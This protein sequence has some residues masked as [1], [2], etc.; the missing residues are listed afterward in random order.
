MKKIS[1]IILVFFVIAISACT[2][3]LELTPEVSATH[4]NFWKTE[5]DAIG[6]VH[7]LMASVKKACGPGQQCYNSLRGFICD[8]EDSVSYSFLQVRWTD[9]VVSSQHAAGQMPGWGSLYGNIFKCHDIIENINRVEW[10]NPEFR[11]FW[12]GQ[13]HF[14]KAYNYWMIVRNFGDAPMVSFKEDHGPKARAP[15]RE[16]LDTALVH[17][18]IARKL[19]PPYADAQELLPTVV[20]TKQ[21]GG[22]GAVNALIAHICAYRGGLGIQPEDSKYLDMAAEACTRVIEGDMTFDDGYSKA[23]EFKLESSPENVCINTLGGDSDE[24]VFIIDGKFELGYFEGTSFGTVFKSIGYPYYSGM[25]TKEPKKG[26]AG[27]LYY[28]RADKMYPVGDLR[29]EAY[30]YQFDVYLNDPES[31]YPYCYKLRKPSYRTSFNNSSIARFYG[32][33]VVFR[34]ADIILLR[35]E[36]Y[37]K[38]GKEDQAVIDLNKIRSRAN[39]DL[40]TNEEYDGDLSMAI[41]RER[42]KELIWEGYR[43]YDIQRNHLWNT[44]LNT[45]DLNYT[46]QDVIDGALWMPVHRLAFKDNGLMRQSVYWNLHLND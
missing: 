18:N 26:P 2:D 4:Y 32:H 16:V 3:D 40:Y 27:V 12:L 5:A 31:I 21:Y 6:V 25:K 14:M 37:A 19:L 45:F 10:S 35:A 1:N 9:D 7:D 43:F 22:R 23:P 38:T 41:F 28:N 44:E 30:F 15:W 36:C 39:A 11:N 46:E 13:A 17:A 34:L 24:Q 33:N 42:E 29:R 8:R 20:D